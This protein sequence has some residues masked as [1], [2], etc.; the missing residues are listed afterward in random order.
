MACRNK[1]PSLGLS[2]VFAA[3]FSYA[4]LPHFPGGFIWSGSWLMIN[5][6]PVIGQQFGGS[7]F[8]AAPANGLGGGLGSGLEISTLNA[9]PL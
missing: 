7:C 6:N 8:L 2:P 4:D 5:V 9:S 3:C 1:Q